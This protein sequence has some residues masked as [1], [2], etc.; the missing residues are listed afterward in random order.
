MTPHDD[1]VQQLLSQG[2]HLSPELR[3]AILA[4]GA[5]SVPALVRILED[6]ALALTT[7]PGEGYAPIHAAD[8]LT[9][10]GGEQAMRSMARVLARVEPGDILY[11]TLLSG[12]TELGPAVAP[13]LLEV[14]EAMEDSDAR[15]GLLSALSRCGAKDERIFQHLLTLL[16]TEPVHAAMDLAS[17]GDPRAIDPL[18]RTFDVVAQTLP[19]EE[20]IFAGHDLV[21]LEAAIADLGG[22]L[23]AHQ[24]AALERATA[25]GRAFAE[26]FN[27]LLATQSPARRTPRPGRNEPCWCGSGVKYKKCHAASDRA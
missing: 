27:R 4:R 16:E 12:L 11:D 17:Y 18:K 2:A 8:L 19:A 20:G 21:E 3:H 1:L 24:Q 10:F 5:A 15:I 23:E 13:A 26:A 14:L 25:A 7:A 6:E 9:E 22:T